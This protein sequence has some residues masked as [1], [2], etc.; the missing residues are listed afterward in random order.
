[1]AAPAQQSAPGTPPNGWRSVGVAALGLLGGFLAAVVLQ[2]IIGVALIRG[3]DGTVPVGGAL[4]IA[5]LIPLLSAIGLAVALL[6]DRAARRR[7]RA[8]SAQR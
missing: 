8:R 1:V 3:A 4:L 5:S 7:E 6:I 2:D